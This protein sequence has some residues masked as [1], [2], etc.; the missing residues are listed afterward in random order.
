[1]YI[2][3]SW[4]N[5]LDSAPMWKDQYYTLDLKILAL[6]PGQVKVRWRSGEGQEG[7]S[8]VR[9]SSEDFKLKDLDLSSTLFLVCTHHH[10]HKLFSHLLRGLDMSDGP[11]MGWY[12]SSRIWG[13]QDF[14]VD[15]KQEI[16]WDYRGTSG[17]TSMSLKFSDSFRKS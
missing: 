17:S 1:M 8:Q 6:S 16:K 14:Q 7:Q 11:R 12:V 10:H 2:N 15:S 4:W 13:G 3:M 5:C 9:S